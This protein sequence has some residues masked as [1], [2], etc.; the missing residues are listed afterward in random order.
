MGEAGGMRA[1]GMKAGR[2][3]H[4]GGRHEGGRHEVG[5]WSSG[6]GGDTFITKVCGLGTAR[7]V[8]MICTFCVS[9]QKQKTK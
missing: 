9:S 4:E 5:G 6:R 8:S 7:G 1:G 2:G 3:R